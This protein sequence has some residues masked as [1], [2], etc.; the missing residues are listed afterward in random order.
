M[1]G[2]NAVDANIEC[3]DCGMRDT[4]TL[5]YVKTS[6]STLSCKDSCMKFDGKDP[7]GQRVVVRSCGRQKQTGCSTN[8]NWNGGVGELCYCNTVLCN[9]SPTKTIPSSII[10]FAIFFIFFIT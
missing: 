7:D 9:I 1:L 8:V 5:P 10:A 2:K 4:C 3:H 6:A